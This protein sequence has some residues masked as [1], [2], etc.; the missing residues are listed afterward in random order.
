MC[1]Q[2]YML[3]CCTSGGETLGKKL[4]FI[5]KN[6]KCVGGLGRLANPSCDFLPGYSRRDGQPPVHSG[7]DPL[8]VFLEVQ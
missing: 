2:R 5:Q 4:V 6:Q 1:E 8:E 3:G 7:G